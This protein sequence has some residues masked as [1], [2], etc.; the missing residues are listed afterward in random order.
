[1]KL[2]NLIVYWSHSVSAPRDS[3][4]I[5]IDA[6]QAWRGTEVTVPEVEHEP[7]VRGKI[8][9]CEVEEAHKVWQPE[10]LVL[11]VDLNQLGLTL[12]WNRESKSLADRPKLAIF[13]HGTVDSEGR[14]ALFVGTVGSGAGRTLLHA[15]DIAKQLTEWSFQG[16]SIDL[17]ACLSERLAQELSTELKGVLVKGYTDPVRV[18]PPPDVMMR[19]KWEDVHNHRGKASRSG[20][21]ELRSALQAQG[22]N[23]SETDAEA[24]HRYLNGILVSKAQWQALKETDLLT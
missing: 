23:L 8:T 16:K 17:I 9:I 1:M 18:D 13:G 2:G 22:F 7:V 20:K 12:K 6:R 10:P 15:R 3:I 11:E 19:D 24:K 14:G 21:E 4:R 5:C